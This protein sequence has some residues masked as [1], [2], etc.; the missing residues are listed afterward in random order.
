MPDDARSGQPGPAAAH[1]RFVIFPRRRIE[2]THSYLGLP[3][4]PRN[5][6]EAL[7]CA[8]TGT[9]VCHHVDEHIV[10][11]LVCRAAAAPG[12]PPE[13]LLRQQ[14]ARARVCAS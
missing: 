6:S 12:V 14:G 2:D 5:A 1:R 7:R 8:G 13:A 11:V 9:H 10:R 3:R 4:A